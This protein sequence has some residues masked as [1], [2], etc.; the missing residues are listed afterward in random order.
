MRGA[1][2]MI[3]ATPNP[4]AALPR[5]P[6][7]A[8]PG[9]QSCLQAFNKRL[10]ADS[11]HYIDLTLPPEPII[12]LH[13]APVVLLSANPGRAPGDYVHYRQP[14]ATG[15]S[16]EDAG[17]A[18]GTPVR[19]LHDDAASSPGGLWWRKLLRD[20]WRV[21]YEYSDLASVLSR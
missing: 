13:E 15:R 10:A 9:D 5:Y 1:V 14:G 8:L 16:L 4:W 12:G 11:P 17:S 7:Y 6:P 21:G 20:L 18:S 3:S 2:P 19:W